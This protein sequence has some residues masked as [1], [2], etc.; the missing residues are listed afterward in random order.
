M[1][2]Q[3]ESEQSQTHKRADSFSDPQV[4]YPNETVSLGSVKEKN[5]EQQDEIMSK[6]KEISE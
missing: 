4:K 1:Q 2:G 6:N 5:N 3:F